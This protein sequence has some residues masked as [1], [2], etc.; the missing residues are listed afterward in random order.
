[1]KISYKDFEIE[2][3]GSKKEGFSYSVVR[4]VIIGF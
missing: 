2:T 4:K 3:L 1:M